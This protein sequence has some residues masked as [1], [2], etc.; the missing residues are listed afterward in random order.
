MCA[1][2]PTPATPVGARAV[3][4]LFGLA[5]L[6]AL[7]ASCTPYEL[8]SILDGPRGM[9]LR[10]EP[11]STVVP[12][13]GRVDFSADGGVPPY[14]FSIV[15]PGGGTLDADTG[16]YTAPITAGSSIIRVTDAAGRSSDA[17]VTVQAFASG[18]ALTPITISLAIGS[19][20]TFTAI[21]GT[22]PYSFTFD[23]A[24]GSGTPVL[25]PDPDPY[26]GLCLYETGA[27]AG[28]DR[29]MVSDSTPTSVIA[30]VAVSYFPS[31]VDYTI[32]ATSLPAAGTVGTT[33]PAGSFTLMNSGSG[34]GAQPVTWKLYLSPNA[35][36]DSGDTLIGT[37]SVSP[38][39]AGASAPVSIS[40]TFPDV[41]GGPYFLL[42]EVSAADNTPSANDVSGA[43][44]VTLDP[45]D[46]DY[47]VV[48]STAAST[49]A[50]AAGAAMS[51]TFTVQ[52]TGGAPGEATLH[53][54]VYASAD[55]TLGGDYLLARGSQPGGLAAGS[56][57]PV[58][59]SGMWPSTPDTWYLIAAVAADDDVDQSAASNTKPSAGTV[60][61]TG[62]APA[63]VE[64]TVTSVTNTGG[65][66]AGDPLTG[67]FTYRNNLGDAG[68]AVV[69]WTAYISSNSTLEIGTD[70][71]IDS[72]SL[73]PLAGL[74]TSGSIGFGGS[75]PVMNGTWNLIVTVSASDDTVPGNNATPT[76]S[77]ITTNPPTVNY[78]AISVGN[79]GATTAGGPFTGSFAIQN[80]GGHA[81][82]QFV[83]WTVYLSEGNGTLDLGT[84]VVIAMGSLAS[85]GLASGGSSSPIP[86]A[87]VWPGAIVSKT[88]RY[89]VHVGA[90]DDVIPVN[91]IVPSGGITVDPPDVKYAVPSVINT[92]GTTAGGL[93]SGQFS[94]T[95]AGSAG[96]S[97]PVSWTAYRS[98][99]NVY[100][101]TDPV[102]DSGT[103]AAIP[104]GGSSGSIGFSGT[105]PPT[106]GSWHLIVRMAA[107][108]DTTSADNETSTLA[109]IALSVLSASY[110][111][112]AVPM[113]AGSTAGQAVSG[114]FTLTN[115]GGLAG[116]S[117]VNWS[118][119]ASPGNSTYDS[120]DTLIA[121]GST[122]PLAASG[123]TSPGYAGT[124]PGTAGN[125]YIVVRAATADDPSIADA[126][127]SLFVGVTD[128]PPPDYSVGFNPAM[129]WSGLVST[130]MNLTGTCQLVIQN[131]NANPGTRTI[132]WSV[133]LSADNVLD[134]GDVLVQ[135]G[136]TGPLAA[137][138]STVVA[139]G[140]N[141][142][143]APGK[144]WHLIAS[145]HS[146]DDANPVNDVVPAP[147]VC[148]VGDSRYKE[149][150][151][152][153]NG[154]GTDPPAAQ[155]STTG[156]TTLG[157][158]QTMVLEG[159]MD[160][161]DQYDTYR[162]TTVASMSRL[163][164]RAQWATGFDDLD[165]YLWDTGSTDLS[166]LEVGI[167]SEPGGGTFEVTGVTPRT[168]YVSAKFWLANDTS[169]STGRTYVIL[170]RG[171]P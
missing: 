1:S 143:G 16:L 116:T 146:P 98:S 86:F 29:V 165:L 114:S 45:P 135:Q 166:S 150:A 13:T 69:Y 96:G 145:V 60:T 106:G 155:T 93:L 148:A 127:S 129:P 149:G 20:V 3:R 21:G 22:P 25:T 144:F 171:L 156:V 101:I 87:G 34:A 27:S 18:L 66:T 37:G 7:L 14:T 97:Q 56:A 159:V 40:G 62:P 125:Y 167:D 53:W 57:M 121:S 163:S 90:G 122:G 118:V 91:N 115:S 108:D 12:A 5:A 46:V 134:A 51:G 85:P 153:N 140:G 68:S 17:T 82:T 126:P 26:S 41:Q 138:G 158:N 162:F 58:A 76:G 104:A 70:P 49:G 31:T 124:W 139:Y 89:I 110:A 103:T 164:M 131:L 24:P 8:R 132:T 119:Y 35:A 61:T 9:A 30:T 67:S 43:S 152:N 4:T 73:P 111:I 154:N 65:L 28:T 113:P 112:T 2:D 100:Q 54:A 39:A 48:A 10:I 36:L 117:S 151:E 64:Y 83:P 38:L 128:P 99:D 74:T 78:T 136:S 94:I 44:A 170:V 23:G 42:A 169:G 55:T 72:G 15:P 80:I 133:H 130:A 75:W 33:I 63:N 137:S 79:T 168:C 107:A 6:L 71:V 142:P 77:S 19:N 32:P 84:D 81:G 160:A 147:H 95:N 88:W 161:F 120:G 109:P 92:G 157:G 59:F 102:I 50:T 47:I 123:S 105:W 11:A 52:N 141:W